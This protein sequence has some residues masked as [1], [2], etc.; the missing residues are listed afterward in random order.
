MQGSFKLTG[1][2]KSVALKKDILQYFVANGNS[3]IQE[4]AKDTSLSVPTVSKAVAELLDLGYVDEFGKQETGEGRRPNLYGLNPGSGYFVGVEVKQHFVNMGL[5]NF[6]GDLIELDD[7]VPCR[8]ENTMES[9]DEL[10]RLVG[11]FIDKSEAGRD[12]ILNVMFCISGRVNSES[13]Y[14]HTLYNFSEQPLTALLSER[15]GYPVHVDNDTRAFAYGEYMKG[16]VDGERHVLFVNMSW[17]LGLG[18]LLDGELYKGKSGFAGELGHTHMFDNDI[19]CHCGKKGCLETE[20]SG[21]AVQRKVRQ[22]IEAGETSVLTQRE[23]DI[24]SLENILDAVAHE[25]P[26]CID[27]IEHVGLTLG[28]SVANLI[29]LFNPDLVVIGGIFSRAGDFLLQSVR[30]SVR[31][32][33]LSMVNKDTRLAL[34]KLHERG[35][36]IGACLLARK[37]VLE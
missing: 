24:Y 16:V 12:K 4:L 18:I 37:S 19:L 8:V 10:C 21:S 9:V 33:S 28:E 29:N 11:E 22:R 26:L 20:A 36:V 30:A 7:N 14:S 5:V 35:G 17:G 6:R 34:S 31:K 25:D 2:S 27:V 13:G 3:T 1:D 23:G 15:I 32:Y